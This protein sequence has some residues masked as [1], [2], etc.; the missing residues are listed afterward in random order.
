MSYSGMQEFRKQQQAKTMNAF[1]LDDGTRRDQEDAVS[2]ALG[3]K[4]RSWRQ[5]FTDDLLKDISSSSN[6]AKFFS[7][8]Q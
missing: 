1:G 7:K 3:L 6:G 8:S 2:M 4:Q 5:N